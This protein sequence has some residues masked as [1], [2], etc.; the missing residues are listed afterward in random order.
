MRSF[1]LRFAHIL[2]YPVFGILLIIHGFQL[3]GAPFIALS[4]GG[5][6]VIN[7][8]NIKIRNLPSLSYTSAEKM[9]ASAGKGISTVFGMLA[10]VLAFLYIL[11]AGCCVIVIIIATPYILFIYYF[12]TTRREIS[13]NPK[14]LF[15]YLLLVLGP[16]F[17]MIYPRI[18]GD[19]NITSDFILCMHTSTLSM[20]G[21]LTLFGMVV[22]FGGLIDEIK[23]KDSSMVRKMKKAAGTLLLFLLFIPPLLFFVGYIYFKLIST[24]HDLFNK[25]I[26]TF[27]L[28]P[29]LIYSARFFFSVNLRTGD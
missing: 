11:F 17:Y 5:T 29:G 23:T 26:Y 2:L 10:A 28:L 15:Y 7:V 24:R 9:T 19:N 21:G 18:F 27:F 22:F 4:N 25:V 6:E 14:G 13:E 20:Y 1:F 16:F 12:R 3:F 8:K